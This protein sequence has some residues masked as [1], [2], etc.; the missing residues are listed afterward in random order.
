[1][2]E[3]YSYSLVP[4]AT[5]AQ[6]PAAPVVV[7]AL[8]PPRADRVAQDKVLTPAA[9]VVPSPSLPALAVPR[10]AVLA[11]SVAHSA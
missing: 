2:V 5:L 6:V 4:A 11:V 7:V 10:L 1:M 8:W 9:P 3:T